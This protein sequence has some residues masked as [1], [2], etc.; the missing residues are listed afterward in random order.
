MLLINKKAKKGGNVPSG[1]KKIHGRRE[2]QFLRSL[3]AKDL[4]DTRKRITG[5]AGG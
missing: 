1:K 2:Q 5:R 4:S 3:G